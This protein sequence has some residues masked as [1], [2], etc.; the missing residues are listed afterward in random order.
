MWSGADLGSYTHVIPPTA[1]DSCKCQGFSLLEL[2]ISVGILAL[3]VLMVI[4]LF[5]YLVF[6]T[7]KSVDETAGTVVAQAALQSEVERLI[8]DADVHDRFVAGIYNLETLISQ[9]STT[10]NH[11]VFTYQIYTVDLP[12][13]GGN[14]GDPLRQLRVV[15]WWWSDSAVPSHQVPSHHTRSDYG[16]LSVELTRMILASGTY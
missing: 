9:G 5:S 4:G 7:Q 16:N 15:C 1:R 13:L 10:L 6:A 14:I 3:A 2:V 8:Y 12:S 11:A